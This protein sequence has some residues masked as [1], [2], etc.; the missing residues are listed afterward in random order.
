M[1]NEAPSSFSME[2]NETCLDSTR[3]RLF[4]EEDDAG[5]QWTATEDSEYSVSQCGSKDSTLE[6]TSPTS[7]A[8]VMGTEGAE[9]ALQDR[10]NHS[11][12]D[13]FAAV[14]TNSLLDVEKTPQRSRDFSSSSCFGTPTGAGCGD[15]GQ[16]SVEKTITSYLEDSAQNPFHSSCTDWQLF[17]FGGCSQTAS[18][19]TY[20]SPSTENIR[21]VLRRR[22][23]HNL[24]ARKVK[25]LRKDIAPFHSSP[26]RSPAKAPALFRNRSF[27]ISD[28]RSA[29]VRVSKDHEPSRRSSF[30]DVLQLCTMPE[31]TTLETPEFCRTEDNTLFRNDNSEDLGYDSDPEDFTRRR[32]LAKKPTFSDERSKSEGF[33]NRGLSNL[34]S[35]PSPNQALFDF[36]ND[37]M[38]ATIVQEIF[39]KTSTLVFH[40][41]SSTSSQAEI[42]QS[43][44]PI[45][46]DA[47]LER[48]QHL[49]YS[50]I[51]PK[52]MWKAKPREKRGPSNLQMQMA[53]LQGVEL[54]DVTRILKV[55]DMA[56]EYSCGQP[57]FAKP[58]HCFLIKS[59]HNEELCFEAKSGE[60]RD[61]LVYALKLVIARFG[62]KVLVGD[63]GIYTEFF[64]VVDGAPGEAPQL[65]NVFDEVDVGDNN[66]GEHLGRSESA[67]HHQS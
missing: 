47:W 39:N 15:F 29:I 30:T 28:H 41:L 33:H 35:I 42:G 1:N 8:I 17:F 54:L 24:R 61:R 46:V 12:T 14:R 66:H 36:Q 48:G 7:V 57:P 4:L 62:A 38:S 19:P 23:S 18:D 32:L 56:G 59:I 20:P 52:W 53:D 11:F 49:A 65:Y 34:E 44:R 31:H 16:V 13:P 43:S 27:S 50:I 40:P 21:N 3:R 6:G 5:S 9:V 22:A 10:T 45:A 55:E 26:A 64:S 2:N 51:Q 67:D 58:S 25:Q 37:E 60:E 63:P